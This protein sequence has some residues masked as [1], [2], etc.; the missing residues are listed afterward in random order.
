MPQ[1]DEKG[2]WQGTACVWKTQVITYCVHLERLTPGND[3]E[4]KG[5]DIQKKMSNCESDSGEI[6]EGFVSFVN[7]CWN[8]RPYL[9]YCSLFR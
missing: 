1:V 4:F 6:L 7:E 3:P 2:G 8:S 5:S 9:P